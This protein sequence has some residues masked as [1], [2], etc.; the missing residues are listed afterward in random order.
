MSC[1]I[2]ST[3][4]AR[5]ALPD[6]LQTFHKFHD[7]DTG[8]NLRRITSGF[9]EAFATGAASRQ[10]TFTLPYIWFRPPMGDLLMLQLLRLVLPNLPY[11]FST[12]HLEYPSVLTRFALQYRYIWSTS[13][14]LFPVQWGCLNSCVVWRRLYQVFIEGAEDGICDSHPT[15]LT[16]NLF[17]VS[18]YMV[19]LMP[20]LSYYILCREWQTSLYREQDE[21]KKSNSTM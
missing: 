8:L 21:E 17:P 7:L 3:S 4:S 15:L 13:S 11:L 18:I 6:F 14:Q 2:N 19:T 16:S 12:F 20:I 1:P 5:S 9:H 10:G